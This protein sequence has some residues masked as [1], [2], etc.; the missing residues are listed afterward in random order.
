[1]MRGVALLYL[2]ISLLGCASPLET[3]VAS[4]GEQGTQFSVY[5]LGSLVRT[6]DGLAARKAVVASLA[7]RGMQ[8]AESAPLRLDV[9]FSALP[10]ALSLSIGDGVPVGTKQAK[11]RKPK[12]TK[13]CEPLEYRLGVAFTKINDG[14]IVY[15]SS[16]F[17]YHCRGN[18]EAVIAAL[19]NA[20]LAD[21]GA[22][23]GT[24][25]VERKF[26]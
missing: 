17:E 3:H 5:Q 12:A 13:K 26:R 2:A 22:P 7:G 8:Q 14:A 21:I 4:S 6:T 20:V 11:H 18:G 24:Y 19:T 15:R 25:S 23:K 1:M 9:T 16:A 10:A